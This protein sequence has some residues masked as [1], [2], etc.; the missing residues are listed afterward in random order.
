MGVGGMEHVRQ[1]RGTSSYSVRSAASAN[2]WRDHRA[3]ERKKETGDRCVPA[4]RLV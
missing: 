4:A 3:S 2:G 1:W